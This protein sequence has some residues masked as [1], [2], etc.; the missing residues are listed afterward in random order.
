MNMGRS[1][2]LF[3]Y[4]LPINSGSVLSGQQCVERVGYVAE[5]RH[6]ART[7]CGEIAPLAGFSV[8]S[9][10]AAELQAISVLKHWVDGQE[11]TKMTLYPSVAFGISMA[12][13]CLSSQLPPQ[14]SYHTV[15]LLSAGSMTEM[16]PMAALAECRLA[17]FKVGRTVPEQ[18]A[19]QVNQLLCRYPH[20]RLRLDANRAWSLSQAHDFSRHLAPAHISRIV[21]IEEPCLRPAD[22]LTFS[23]ET[24]LALAW[25]ETFQY[26][27]RAPDFRLNRLAGAQ[28]LVLKP[29]LIGSVQRCAQL[30][31]D[32]HA[33]GM[34][35]VISSALESSLGLTQLARL[36]HWLLPDSL[37]GLDTLN[38]FS[39]QLEIPWPG[40]SLPV[41]SLQEQT[42]VWQS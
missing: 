12:L 26:A 13:M 7:G 8:E 27:A 17:K 4:R 28:T 9:T 1:A 38:L 34:S 33:A 32:A 2:R 30:I 18:E 29:T 22:C 16:A 37:P 6:Q 3:R 31:G 40:S 39:A 41:Q 10:E 21:F 23:R 36:S 20:L 14:A 25:D 5:L 35:V 19:E 42:Q 11:M 15:P 24:G